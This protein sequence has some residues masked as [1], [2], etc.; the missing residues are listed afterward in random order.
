MHDHE[1]RAALSRLEQSGPGQQA[2][3]ERAK[4]AMLDEFDMGVHALESSTTVQ[5]GGDDPAAEITLLVREDTALR[6]RRRVQT[7][8]PAAAA[9]IVIVALVASQI[10]PA[11]RFD[12]ERLEAADSMTE[13][14]ARPIEEGADRPVGERRF[15]D[16]DTPRPIDGRFSSEALG[17]GLSFEAAET[18]WLLRHEDDLIWLATDPRDPAAAQL[19]IARP[20]QPDVDFGAGSVVDY[21]TTGRS[22]VSGQRSPLVVDGVES[23][24]WRGRVETG[25]GEFASCSVEEVCLMLW[26]SPVPIGLRADVTNDII[27]RPDDSGSVVMIAS[28][29]FEQFDI[30]PFKQAFDDVLA[31]IEFDE[32]TP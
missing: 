29:P 25:Q 15:V 32:S 3:S 1:V 10:L 7:L 12:P 4:R 22:G 24:Y 6:P 23:S 20:S 21:L 17:V 27:E 8:I 11:E 19:V 9:V 26:K 2:A 31:T 28:I 16:D 18:L 30:G 5:D 14:S 13:D